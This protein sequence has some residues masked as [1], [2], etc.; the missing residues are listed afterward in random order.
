MTLA[1]TYVRLVVTPGSV[2]HNLYSGL[3]VQSIRQVG[4]SCEPGLHYQGC[5]CCG[6]PRVY[7]IAK[8][9]LYKLKRVVAARTKHSLSIRVLWHGENVHL[10]RRSFL[11]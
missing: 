9:N 6:R 3:I 10:K 4:Y 2:L 11:D 8:V 1:R 7:G 5:L